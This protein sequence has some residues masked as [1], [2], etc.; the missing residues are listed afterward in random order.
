M[1]PLQHFSK[2]EIPKTL[3]WGIF[4][5]SPTI[6]FNSHIEPIFQVTSCGIFSIFILQIE[7]L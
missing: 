6:F 4:K 3:V 1:L 5:V 7:V 2:K